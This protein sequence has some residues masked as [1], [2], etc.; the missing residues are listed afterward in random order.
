LLDTVDANL[1]QWA[2]VLDQKQWPE[3]ITY[4]LIFGEMEVE[5][6]LTGFN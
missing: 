1:A 5:T 4:Q 3:N 2:H 6:C